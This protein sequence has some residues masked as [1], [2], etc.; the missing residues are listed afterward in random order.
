M[1]KLAILL[2]SLLIT[3]CTGAINDFVAGGGSAGNNRPPDPLPDADLQA[4][5]GF[6]LS[7]G[8]VMA[9]GASVNMRATITPTM[10]QMTSSV[11]NAQMSL[12]ASPTK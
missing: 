6:K 12:H 1:R 7:P 4:T 2:C 8:S 11:G 9:T 5:R 10:R 3:A